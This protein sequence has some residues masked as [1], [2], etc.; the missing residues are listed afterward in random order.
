[1]P[2]PRIGRARGRVLAVPA[3]TYTEQ[4][5]PDAA[6]RTGRAFDE[7]ARA[8][9]EDQ[10]AV[11]ARA[12]ATVLAALDGFTAAAFT[13]EEQARRAN[14]LPSVSRP[15]PVEYDHGTDDGRVTIPFELQEGLASSRARSRAAR[16]LHGVRAARPDSACDP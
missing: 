6:G 3:P 16:P 15:V 4:N 8:A 9:E 13:D 11:F 7:L 14:Q 12:H 10:G 2:P 5:G 1:M